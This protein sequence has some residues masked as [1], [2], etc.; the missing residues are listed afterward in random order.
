MLM[1]S[2]GL[3]I[4]LFF[5]CTVPKKN[6]SSVKFFFMGGFQVVAQAAGFGFQKSQAGPKA[7]SSQ[8]QGPNWPGFFWPGFWPQAGAGT[9]LHWWKQ[10]SLFLKYL[11]EFSFN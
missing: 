2:Y 11:C 7:S 6:P 1:I 3:F 10:S 5:N 8:T 4:Y 9:S